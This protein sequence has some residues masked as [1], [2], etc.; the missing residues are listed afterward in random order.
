MMKMAAHIGR[1]QERWI[2]IMIDNLVNWLF[3]WDRLRNAIFNEV[4][5]YNSITRILAD[6]VASSTA[7]AMWDEGDGWRGWTI[8]DDG[9]YYFHDIPE[10]GMSDIM[11][12]LMEIEYE[13]EQ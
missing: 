8:K 9:R 13:K 5:M 3:R 7:T 4:N 10:P 11:D 2:Q 12:V 6:P 1:K